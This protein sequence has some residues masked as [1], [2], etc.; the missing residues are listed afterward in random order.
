MDDLENLCNTKKSAILC[1]E[2]HAEDIRPSTLVNHM[3]IVG[4]INFISQRPEAG[5]SFFGA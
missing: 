5:K 4:K 2:N 3:S 1:I